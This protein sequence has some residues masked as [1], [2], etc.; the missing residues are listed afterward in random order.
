MSFPHFK[1]S[2]NVKKL[3]Y[4]NTLNKKLINHEN[5]PLLCS[6][7]WTQWFY[8]LCPWF[9]YIVDT[10]TVTGDWKSYILVGVFF[11][12]IHTI[13]KPILKLITLPLR[14]ITLGLINLIINGV[15]LWVL[16]NLLNSLDIWNIHI[17]IEGF[18]TYCFAGLLLSFFQSFLHIFS[19]SKWFPWKKLVQFSNKITLSMIFISQT[20]D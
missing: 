18:L 5:T 6:S 12:I 8:L 1:H 13:L 3:V 10:F 11:G 16:E 19:P 7:S 4:K 2:K 17:S 9:L 14:L 15:L 20:D